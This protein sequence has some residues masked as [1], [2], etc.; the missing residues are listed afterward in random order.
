M[1]ERE[2]LREHSLH[3]AKVKEIKQRLH[4]QLPRVAQPLPAVSRKKRLQL[5]K[6]THI[7]Y[8]NQLLLKKMIAIGSKPV[9]FCHIS[10]V[11]SSL[12]RRSR[13][14]ELTRISA[15]NRSFVNR[16]KRTHSAYSVKRWKEE[17]GYNVNLRKRLSENSGR[18]PRLSSYDSFDQSPG[19]SQSQRK[20]LKRTR[21]ADLK[22]L[23]A[24]V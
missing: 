14:Q 23:S 19:V 3:K 1:L 4:S 15:E 18:V 6:S 2:R 7:R 12:N 8:E 21:S 20:T 24:E 17:S 22:K 5:E 9:T 11:R 16:L 13:I 10:P